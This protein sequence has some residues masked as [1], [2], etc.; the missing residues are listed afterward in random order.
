MTSINVEINLDSLFIE[1]EED[2]G[3][4]F[5]EALRSSIINEA[6]SKVRQMVSDQLG[7]LLATAIN[8]HIDGMIAAV[9]SERIAKFHETEEF[10]SN[11]HG[12][13]TLADVINN[14]ISG[15]LTSDQMRHHI[16]KL[17]SDH[18][19]DIKASYDSRYAAGIVE[20]LNRHNLLNKGAAKMLLDSDS[21]DR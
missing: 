16:D 19:K 5:S 13:K 12:M 2:L 6:R 8:G 18:A 20:G 3:L 9:V 10:K 1:D 7:P 4:S 15:S 21:A 14:K 11:W 17:A